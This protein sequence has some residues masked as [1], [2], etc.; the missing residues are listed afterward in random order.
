MGP[1]CGCTYDKSPSI[2]GS[3]PGALV[4]S[5]YTGSCVGG[6]SDP[7][8]RA[9][10]LG[11]VTKAHVVVLYSAWAVEGFQYPCFGDYVC[12]RPIFGFDRG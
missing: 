3:M 6:S 1:F 2:L 7:Y 11:A 10:T 8:Q 12:A 9:I 4:S 5:R